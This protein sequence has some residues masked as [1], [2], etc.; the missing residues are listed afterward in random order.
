MSIKEMKEEAQL[1]GAGISLKRFGNLTNSIC[2][3]QCHIQELLESSVIM[4]SLRLGG[5]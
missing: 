5:K 4:R 2:S 3:G 1:D